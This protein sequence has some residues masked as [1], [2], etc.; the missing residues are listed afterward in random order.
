MINSHYEMN[1]LSRNTIADIPRRISRKW[2]DKICLIDENTRLTYAQLHE[3]SSR[4]ANGL[5]QMGYKKGDK[6]SLILSNC[7]QFMI[8]QFAL[9]KAGIITVPINLTL[10]PDE[11]SFIIN[12][13]EST[14]LIIEDE[15]LDALFEK[16]DNIPAIKNIISI[17]LKETSISVK[18]INYREIIETS[19]PNEPE[20]IIEDRDI[21]IFAYTSGTEALPK[22]VMLSHE[23]LLAEY[24]DM[25]ADAY[26][27]YS[28][29][30]ITVLPLYHNAAMQCFVMPR[31]YVGG[32][33]II[34]EKFD[35]V[36]VLE[37]IQKERATSFFGL[38]LMYRAILEVPDFN[39]YDLTS[40]KKCYY[41]M[42][43]MPVPFLEK[44]IEKFKAGFMI[45]LGMTETVCGAMWLKPEDQLK[46]P[47]SLGNAAINIEMATMDDEGNL[48][49]PGQIGE[50]VY[51]GKQVM[52]G[53][54]KDEEK[55]KEAFKYGWYHSG[56]LGY[57]DEDGYFFFVDRK[58]D[59]IKTGG[60]NV[61]TL[62]I[63]KVILMHPKVQDVAVIGVPDKR[64]IE[65]V[66]AI[67]IPKK[68]IDLTKEEIIAYCKQNL[69]G[70][71]VPKHVIFTNAIP[72]TSTGK[73]QKAILRK[74]YRPMFESN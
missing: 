9:A 30:G 72:K 2:P 28:D 46:K 37:I 59:M 8:V 10:K 60:E 33:E 42:A 3:Q 74:Q 13:S 14:G 40:L 61:S 31:M 70:Y 48:L 7:Y 1:I 69:S 62:E 4:L 12:H 26:Y 68:D 54:Y 16:K 64:W 21:A 38:P 25:I 29:I 15:Y 18:A 50:L 66:T 24:V 43:P 53:Y 6:I 57:I 39:H 32:T 73:I 58:K 45:P 52:V 49:P 23:N 27:H 36:E 55:T 19:P 56:D 71:K 34:L 20:V 35:P 44:C 41:A 67:V 22:G 65:A 47:G 11:M 51:R 17:P 63:E 5:I